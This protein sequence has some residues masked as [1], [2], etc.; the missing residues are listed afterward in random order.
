[1]ATTPVLLPPLLLLFASAISPS[2][3]F[4]RSQP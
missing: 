2:N 3:L 4:V 1:M